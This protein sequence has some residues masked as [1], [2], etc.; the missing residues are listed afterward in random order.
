MGASLEVKQ[1][2]MDA[3]DALASSITGTSVSSFLHHRLDGAFDFLHFKQ[4]IVDLSSSKVLGYEITTALLSRGLLKIHKPNDLATAMPHATMRDK[5][6][7]LLVRQ[8][9]SQVVNRS[10]EGGFFWFVNISSAQTLQ[11]IETRLFTHPSRVVLECSLPSFEDED[12]LSDIIHT[13]SYLKDLGMHIAIE[14]DARQRYNSALISAG[15][16]DY[17]KT[18]PSLLAALVGQRP[19]ALKSNALYWIEMAQQHH[20][21]VIGFGVESPAHLADLSLLDIQYV[22]GYSLKHPVP[23]RSEVFKSA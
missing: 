1:G 2:L 14:P 3:Q 13:L 12:R 19:S 6:D 20:I 21:P 8:V 16:V 11:R 22:Q 9:A 17:L 4:A 18:S 23:V 7:E 5:F 15:L 10:S